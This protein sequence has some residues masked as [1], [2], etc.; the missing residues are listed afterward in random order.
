MDIPNE[1]AKSGHIYFPEFCKLVLDRFRQISDFTTNIDGHTI[2]TGWH[3]SRKGGTEDDLFRQN[4][5]KV[6]LFLCFALKSI[7][8]YRQIK[9]F[10]FRWCVV[11]T[12]SQRIS[13]PRNTGKQ[14]QM[15]LIIERNK[16][17][18]DNNEDQH[19]FPDWRS[20]RWTRRT[21]PSSW[22]TCR[23]QWPSPRSTRC[24]SSPI[25]TRTESS[26]LQSLSSWWYRSIL[27][28]GI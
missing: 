1:I 10:P 21:L 23:C 4:M 16:H 8:L 27:K 6:L 20:T 22:G 9:T 25:K 18:C 17:R 13:K 11:Q 24:S 5:F 15:S 19:F 26:P 28:I 3:I 12:P 2:L 7:I 14:S